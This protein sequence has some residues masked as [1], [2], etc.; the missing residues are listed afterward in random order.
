MRRAEMV[1]VVVGM[2]AALCGPAADAWGGGGG[3]A[4]PEFC[5]VDN[6]GAGAR[7]I[8]GTVNVQVR[9]ADINDGTVPQEVDFTLRL[10]RSG[11]T[12]FFRLHLDNQ[13]ILGMTNEQIACV[14]LSNPSLVVA[15]LDAFAPGQREIVI[16][17]KSITSAEDRLATAPVFAGQNHAATMAD[18]TLYAR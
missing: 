3:P 7:A 14:M 1:L 16:T 10:E 9:S 18:F 11:V 13:L 17:D 15:I 8:R 5:V 4:G 6:P 2:V 12:R